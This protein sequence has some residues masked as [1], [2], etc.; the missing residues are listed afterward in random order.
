M[1]YTGLQ[2]KKYNRLHYKQHRAQVLR[3][4]K[5]QYKQHK[6]D[7]LKYIA[8]WQKE[9][10]KKHGA[11]TS[12]YQKKNRVKYNVYFQVRRTKQTAAGGEYTEVQWKSLCRKHSYRC[13][14]CNRRRK[15]TPDHVVPVSKGG[16]SSI[17]NIQP[18]CGPCNSS[19]GTRTIDYRR[20]KCQQ[21]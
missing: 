2:K 6:T 14:R 8:R 13:L 7:R 15:L 17:Q 11:Y 20:I 5:K 4:A 9:N 1:P 19:K 3:K 12:K 10:A 18:L 21:P 16:T